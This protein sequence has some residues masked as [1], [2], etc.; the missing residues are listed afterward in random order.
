MKLTDE[1]QAI[2]AHRDGPA[3]AAAVAGAAKTTSLILR[4][5][6]ILETTMI[7]PQDIL[8][9]TFSRLGVSD[10][11]RRAAQL[12]L[13]DLPDIRTIH[14]LAWR[15]VKSKKPNW[16][17]P[18]EWW[19]K[20]VYK[21]ALDKYLDR[22]GLRDEDL[23]D[24]PS[25]ASLSMRNVMQI[26]G[27]AKANLILPDSWTDASGTV[28]PSFREWAGSRVDPRL[29]QASE[30]CYRTFEEVRK[31]LASVKDHKLRDYKPGDVACT[32]DDALL[33]VAKAILKGE[34]WVKGA[35]GTYRYVVMDEAQ[36]T[37]AVQWVIV[38]H[39]AKTLS[40]RS[41]AT[42]GSETW[43]NL[44]VCGDDMQTVY[45][46]RGARPDLLLDFM[47]KEGP[48]L[49][50]FPL[51]TNFRSGQAIL[52]V[53]NRILRTAKKRL[54]S[55]ELKCGRNEI[56]STVATFE[57][58]DSTGEA[59]GVVNGIQDSLKAGRAPHE[60][61][62]LY[63]INAQS[64]GVELELIRRGIPYRVTG[65][66]FFERPEVDAAIKYIALAL[67][68]ADEEAFE[69]V[70][71]CPFRFI[72]RDLLKH[73]PNFAALRA[74]PKGL[75]AARWKGAVR[76]LRDMDNLAAK[77]KRDGLV[78]A[79]GY[80][81]DVIGVRAHA[82]RQEDEED[83]LD[84][85]SSHASQVDKAIEELVACAKVA[86]DPMK[87]LEYVRDKREEVMTSDYEG[88]KPDGRVCLTTVHRGKGMEWEEVFVVG[89]N[90]GL[91]PLRGAPLDE[92]KRLG[93]VAITR[94]KK[95]LWISWSGDRP[96]SLVYDAGLLEHMRSP[97]DSALE[98]AAT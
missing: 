93:Y 35:A 12:G 7:V 53:A 78:A 47:I 70:Y 77:L 6:A 98:E 62:V 52:D 25:A 30:I 65:R 90:P 22:A 92:E 72:S 96:S 71:K 38:R 31:N 37:S 79:L 87:F 59:F 80:V 49:S 14:S 36:D 81:F 94:A 1:Q 48:S 83:D 69:A 46:F 15:I 43:Q 56:E 97:E 76:L 8:L 5:K 9:T 58:G 4:T 20:K 85:E 51:T 23:D 75:V 10:L 3:L 66:C 42:G 21:T 63:R 26:I 55:G 73:F 11:K 86:G 33:E 95:S 17:L 24:R 32:H 44:M 67:D 2:I 45:A 41:S 91:F 84:D 61:A 74:H 28:Y 64:G 82:K 57:A 18:P 13:R 34:E 40:R 88:E 54:F 89:M 68:E 60:I 39:V 50:F 19:V 29:A 16:K 27:I